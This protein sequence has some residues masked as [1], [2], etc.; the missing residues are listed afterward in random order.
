[1][2]VYVVALIHIH[3]RKTY[4]HYEAGFMEIFSRYQGRMLAVDED[5]V[6]LEGEWPYTRTVLIEF[7][8][9]QAQDAWYSSVDYQGLMQHR[10][11][12]SVASIAVLNAL[13]GT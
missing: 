1:M 11:A 8:N 6:T 3:D 5:P 4:G 13:P 9:R 7:P 2:T 10:T 12:A